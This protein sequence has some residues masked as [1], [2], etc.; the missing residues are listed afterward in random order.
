MK[1]LRQDLRELGEDGGDLQQQQMQQQRQQFQSSTS[2]TYTSSLTA[3]QLVKA[4]P[5][6]D[7]EH[8]N[9]VKYG[10]SSNQQLP[11]SG[12]GSGNAGNPRNSLTSLRSGVNSISGLQRVCGANAGGATTSS[13]SLSARG[14]L[15]RRT[16]D[17]GCSPRE[18]EDGYATPPSKRKK[19][20]AVSFCLADQD[21]AE[22]GELLSGG[23]EHCD[24]SDDGHHE[25]EVTRLAAP[26]R[27]RSQ[28]TT[29]VDNHMPTLCYKKRVSDRR[30]DDSDGDAN[31]RPK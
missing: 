12:F 18:E 16:H 9:H 23:G 7:A 13:G 28:T 5:E 15:K 4:R 10:N 19:A 26:A 2:S 24:K 20:K 25:G 21:H 31:G 29:D 17:E 27:E 22:G 30:R 14:C 6:E 3:R 11:L 1:K 8:V